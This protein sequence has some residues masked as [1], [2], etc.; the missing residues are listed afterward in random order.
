[1]SLIVLATAA[2]LAND[3]AH[4][5]ESQDSYQAFVTLRDFVEEIQAVANLPEDTVALEGVSQLYKRY[6]GKTF[7]VITLPSGYLTV[8]CYADETTVPTELGGAQDL[9]MDGDAQD[10][11]SGVAGIDLRIVPVA[12]SVSYMIEGMPKSM[13]AYRLVTRTID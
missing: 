2:T 12:V 11:L 7:P 10:D 3:T 4:R 1:M 5:R 9:N 13:S 6:N 8:T